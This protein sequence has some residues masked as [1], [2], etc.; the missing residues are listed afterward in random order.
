MQYL[1]IARLALLLGALA[2]VGLAW[3]AAPPARPVLVRFVRT[4]GKKGAGQGEFHVPIGIAI[5]RQDRVWVAAKSNRVQLFT[6]EGR[7][8]GGLGR[9]GHG[10]GEF[11]TPHGLAVDGQGCLYV[12]DTQNHRVQ[13][14]AP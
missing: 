4:W 6:A 5:D 12:A 3:G 2:P 7:Y 14:F 9:K 8:L 13:K 10:A 11:H 1:P